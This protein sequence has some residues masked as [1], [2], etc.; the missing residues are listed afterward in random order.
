MKKE[1]KPKGLIILIAVAALLLIVT[2]G[3]ELNKI[4]GIQ[5]EGGGV[6]IDIGDYHYSTGGV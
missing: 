4:P 1:S 2:Q 5:V 6:S 3:D